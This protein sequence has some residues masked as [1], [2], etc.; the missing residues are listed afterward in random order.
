MSRILVAAVL[1]LACVAACG[2]INTN[3]LADAPMGGSNGTAGGSDRRRGERRGRVTIK[4][5][6]QQGSGAPLVGAPVLF[7]DSTGTQ[8]AVTDATG[9]A[10][11]EGRGGRDRHRD[12]RRDGGEV[13]TCRRCT[14]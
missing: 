8:R 6:D 9:T 13:F 2:D 14:A 11:V 1:L 3:H 7:T 12:Q 10:T 4:V 5:L